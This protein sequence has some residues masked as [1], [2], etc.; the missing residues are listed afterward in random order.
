M[1]FDEAVKIAEGLDILDQAY[2][3]NRLIN[4]KN[5][6]GIIHSFYMTGTCIFRRFRGDTNGKTVYIQQASDIQVARR[7]IWF[8][9]AIANRPSDIRKLFGE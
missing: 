8:C 1:T 2:P 5:K 3:K 4:C 9:N 6:D 7:F